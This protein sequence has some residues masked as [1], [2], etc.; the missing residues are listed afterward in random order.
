MN[1]IAL[2]ESQRSFVVIGGLARSLTNFRQPLLL[3]LQQSGHVVS[4]MAGE[5]DPITTAKLKSLAIDFD[6]VE[7]SRTS[8][9]PIHDIG[10]TVQIQRLLRTKKPSAVLAYTAKPVIFGLL[11]AR[12]AG[13]HHRYAL[14]TGLGFGLTGTS[15]KRK[16]LAQLLTGLYKL[17]LAGSHIVFFQNPDDEALFR[18]RIL[19]KRTRSVVVRGSGVDT[20]HFAPTPLPD[21]DVVRFLFIGRFLVEKGLRE[22]VEATRMLRSSTTIPFEVHTVGWIDPN[23]A[24][25]SEQ[26]LSGWIAEGLIINHGR[27][28]EVRPFVTDSHVLVLPSYREGTPRS[29]LEAMSMQRAVI[30]TDAP[31]CREP[32]VHGETGLL[33][34][35]QD[36]ISLADAMRML[37][38]QKH[39]I[40][41]YGHAGRLR[42]QSLYEA[43][44]VAAG[45]VS[46]IDAMLLA[47][48]QQ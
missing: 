27:V 35:V 39:L 32:V 42:I 45:M 41:Q 23:P 47:A 19:F 14:I 7:L 21:C 18:Q 17:A 29:V 44:T 13:V 28:D 6:A 4:T 16:L 33:V 31:G 12:L 25:I 3:A 43:S 11:A 22:L 24:G 36:S 48:P 20:A 34:P 40:E 37:L 9:N 30:T 8:L 26:E 38:E 10:T 2:S 46:E 5:P 15:T 1:S